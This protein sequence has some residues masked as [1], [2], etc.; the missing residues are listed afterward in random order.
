MSDSKDD[1][2]V[3][4]RP[5]SLEVLTGDFGH[6]PSAEVSQTQRDLSV[7]E[8]IG[9][10]HKERSTLQELLKSQAGGN[11]PGKAAQTRLPTPSI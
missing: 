7:L 10:Q 8:A 6:L 5:Q 9:I 4:N 3:F 11:A 2:E 1:L